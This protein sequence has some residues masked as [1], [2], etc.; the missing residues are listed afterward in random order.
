MTELPLCTAI[1]LNNKIGAIP[2]PSKVT[3]HSQRWSFLWKEVRG[4]KRARVR[5]GGGETRVNSWL[6]A[7]VGSMG[8]GMEVYTETKQDRGLGRQPRGS[9][10]S[11]CEDKESIP[12]GGE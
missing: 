8:R 10:K 7:S 1:K 3:K 4:L 6:P 5:R 2:E 9:R 12:G 11:G